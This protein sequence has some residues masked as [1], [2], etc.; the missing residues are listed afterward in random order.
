MRVERLSKVQV[1]TITVGAIFG[2]DILMVQHHMVKIA[3]QDGWISL[4][5]G[6]LLSIGFAFIYYL[7]A[8]LHPDLDMPEIKLKLCGPFLGRLLL[9]PTALYAVLYAG[10]SARI[11]AQALKMFLLDRTPIYAIIALML[12]VVAYSV[13]KGI[14]VIGSISDVIFPL[15]VFTVVSMLLLSFQQVDLDR[16]KPVL[17]ENM[18][19]VIRGIFP[20]FRHFMGFGII[21]YIYCHT[22]QAKGTYKWFIAGLLIPIA[23]YVL[24]TVVSIGVFSVG[25]L[26][27]LIFPTLTL[28][29]SIEFPA[30]FLERL[31]SFTAVIWIA[32]V[33]ESLI[34]FFYIS[35]RDFSVL[36]GISRKYDR[37]TIIV[38]IIAAYII[39]L[40]EPHGIQVL[41]YFRI[42]VSTY[43]LYS[44]II[45]PLLT[46][47][48][49]LKRRR[50]KQ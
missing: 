39:S 26:E 49:L 24:L 22:Y 46:G 3:R 50:S 7:L 2:V 47:Y 25:S 18:D 42:L 19:N 37:Y 1:M 27:G 9:F 20:G 16:L 8:V 11:F 29:K 4:A 14:Y 23:F 13:Y 30:T 34:V 43:T 38:L 31:E 45:V 12:V 6:G 33:F 41:N 15:C 48:A 5:I 36:F 44:L 35:I 10:L 17:F 28:S 40:L 21:A 32:I